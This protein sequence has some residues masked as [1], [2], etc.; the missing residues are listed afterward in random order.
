MPALLPRPQAN[1]RPDRDA[2]GKHARDAQVAGEIV[3]DQRR[4][5]NENR[6]V[7]RSRHDGRVPEPSDRAEGGAHAGAEPEKRRLIRPVRLRQL[8]LHGRG[9]RSASL[10]TD[11][12]LLPGADARGFGPGDVRLEH[13]RA[14]R[15]DREKLSCLGHFGAG[16]HGASKHGAVRGSDEGDADE[17]ALREPERAGRFVALCGR[18]GLANQDLGSAQCRA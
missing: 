13:H 2:V 3:L 16:F 12:R 15:H 8:P 7:D 14:D 5:W 1:R 6:P 9:D 17:I 4:V 11:V 18:A 10:H